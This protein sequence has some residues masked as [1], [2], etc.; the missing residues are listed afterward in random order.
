[1]NIGLQQVVVS[2]LILGFIAVVGVIAFAVAVTH[3]DSGNRSA[4]G[5]GGTQPSQDS[6]VT[7]G[8][9]PNRA[10]AAGPSPR[11]VTVHYDRASTRSVLTRLNMLTAFIWVGCL[12]TCSFLGIPIGTVMAVM[13]AGWADRNV[14]LVREA[15][16]TGAFLG[17]LVGGAVGAGLAWL[18]TVW[19]GW[20][21]QVLTAL[22]AILAVQTG[23]EGR[24]R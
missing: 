15:A 24:A 6:P 8:S 10:A 20:A 2:I 19:L 11:P 9:P 5:E 18:S 4:S 1:M 16:G 12:L 23:Q 14:D 3:Q 7:P 17:F 22:D 21:A 13:L